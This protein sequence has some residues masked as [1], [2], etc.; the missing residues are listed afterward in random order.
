MWFI[1]VELEHETRAP[2]PKKNPGSAPAVTTFVR[3]KE[4]KENNYALGYERPL[5]SVFTKGGGKII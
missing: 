5:H 2:P 4:R 1:G 3:A